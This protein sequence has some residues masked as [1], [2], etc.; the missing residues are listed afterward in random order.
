MRHAGIKF[1]A[2][3]L[4]AVVALNAQCM[5]LCAVGFCPNP[6]ETASH[7]HCHHHQNPKAPAP[8]EA[9]NC[10]PQQPFFARNSS[11]A[12][13]VPTFAGPAAVAAPDCADAIATTPLPARFEASPP[14]MA[15]SSHFVLRI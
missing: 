15:S 2:L 14:G 1:A 11:A 12:F 9:H 7:S 6:P 5:A 4:T 8:G 13:P 10:A 3:V